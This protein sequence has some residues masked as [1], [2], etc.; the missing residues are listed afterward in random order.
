MG[1]YLTT[2]STLQCPHGGMVSAVPA[3]SKVS[4]G[5]SP[6]VLSS[7]TFII[8]GCAFNVAGAPHPCLQ[9]QWIVTALSGTADGS[10]PL[11]TDSAGLCKA[12]DGA[13]QGPV[14]IS[15]TQAKVSGL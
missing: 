9:V 6:I 14:T 1:A 3:N 5:G 12:A 10:Q 2:S 15:A 4:L 11:T 8:G 13:V 7:D